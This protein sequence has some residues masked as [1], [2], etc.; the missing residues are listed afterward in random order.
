MACSKAVF[1]ENGELTAHKV[2]VPTEITN[3]LCTY[4]DFVSS[5]LEFVRVL[6]PG[7]KKNV[8]SQSMTSSEMSLKGTFWANMCKGLMC[9]EQ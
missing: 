6:D 7:E 1:K 9:H 8:N 4:N 5:Y 3:Y 2:I